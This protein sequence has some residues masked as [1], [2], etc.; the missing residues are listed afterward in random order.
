M[1]GMLVGV[2]L[3]GGVDPFPGTRLPSAGPLP[4]WGGGVE[5]GGH[6]VMRVVDE[7]ESSAHG[8]L[9]AD[10]QVAPRLRVGVM[11]GLG[12]RGA[13]GSPELLQATDPLEL[14]AHV[15]LTVVQAPGLR[16]GAWT[17]L[18]TSYGAGLALWGRVGR[19]VE[20]DVSAGVLFR[21]DALVP[22]PDH[23]WA[24]R[25][26]G[27]TM[28]VDPTIASPEIGLTLCLD[29][30]GR[31]RLR[32]G[33]VDTVPTFSWRH[34]RGPVSVELSAGTLFVS[35]VAGAAVGVTF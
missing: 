26:K 25:A 7:L 9:R 24:W 14:S 8:S 10:L 32:W 28:V 3:A 33:L 13:A 4:T 15:G 6:G 2:A 23:A 27:P 21:T 17:Q 16:V 5:L 35:T 18:G 29:D 34:Q 19:R 22:D 11:A 30:A 20:V 1:L 12:D 31:N